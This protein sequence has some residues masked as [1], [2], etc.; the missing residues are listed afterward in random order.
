[1]K[2]NQLESFIFIAELGS[3][4]SASEK[5]CVTQSTISSRIHEL[6]ASLGVDLFDRSQRRA[7]LTVKGRELL[8]HARQILSAVSEIR[9]SVG[10]KDS[11][12]GTIRIGVVE[13]VALSWLPDF[14]RDVKETYHNIK[15]EFDVGLNPEI[16]RNL[17]RGSIDL[18][19]VAGSQV[20]QDIHVL[21]L[22]TAR[23]AW[24]ASDGLCPTDEFYDMDKILSVGVLYQGE[25]SYTNRVIDG[26]LCN[27]GTHRRGTTCNSLGALFAMARSGNGAGFLP[28]D[29]PENT[30][31]QSGL[32]TLKTDPPHYDM[33]FSITFMKGA[34]SL[35]SDLSKICQ[36]AS[37]FSM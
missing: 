10:A 17:R 23:F 30:L 26:L 35:M 4:H 9:R 7:R 29:F 20:E 2:F 5:L 15:L 3:F 19:I 8:P 13:M 24:M 37:K 21:P 12:T 27:A 6:E 36:N 33:P 18:A 28:L 11:L 34:N 1:M 16:Y 22:G 25:D 14:V 31:T 32:R